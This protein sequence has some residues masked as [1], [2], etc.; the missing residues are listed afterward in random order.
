ML[1]LLMGALSLCSCFINAALWES[2]RMVMEMHLNAQRSLQFFL[3]GVV[4][5]ERINVPRVHSCLGQVP[6]MNRAAGLWAFLQQRG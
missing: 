3:Y 5:S 4:P 2:L 6:S 1:L